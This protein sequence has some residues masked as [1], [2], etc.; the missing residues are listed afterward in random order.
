M[1]FQKIFSNSVSV[2]IYRKNIDNEAKR[3][4]DFF[5]DYYRVI[6]TDQKEN[7]PASC[8]ILNILPEDSDSFRDFKARFLWIEKKESHIENENTV[9][10]PMK[11][12][13][14]ELFLNNCSA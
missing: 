10:G 6:L 11:K 2:C 12:T 8:D 13:Y 4:K 5:E 9:W 14:I 7:I 3:L 1:L